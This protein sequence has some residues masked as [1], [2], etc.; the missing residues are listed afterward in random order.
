MNKEIVIK[1]NQ[2]P[3][4]GRRA[5]P[6]VVYRQKRKGHLRTRPG[7]I[8][9]RVRSERASFGARVSLPA[10]GRLALNTQDVRVERGSHPRARGA[11]GPSR[12][13]RHYRFTRR[14]TDCYYNRVRASNDHVGGLIES[15][16][17]SGAKS[18]SGS[19]RNKIEDE[20]RHQNHNRYQNL[21][22]DGEQNRERGQDQ[23]QKSRRSS[24]GITTFFWQSSNLWLRAKCN[25]D[26]FFD[27]EVSVSPSRRRKCGNFQIRA[28]HLHTKGRPGGVSF[29]SYKIFKRQV[30]A[31]GTAQ[32]RA[33]ISPRSEEARDRHSTHPHDYLQCV[34]F[35]MLFLRE[36]IFNV[37]P[38]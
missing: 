1:T 33:G 27:T 37:P 26:S 20:E 15:Q 13:R 34:R 30:A 28:A 19:D 5:L 35:D 38:C 12:P 24:V 4:G 21:K 31:P 22:R 16:S 14:P 17:R 32:G 8:E 25:G 9:S 7:R 10:P 29:F 3:G 6:L 23:N 2:L 11:A 18:E 36:F